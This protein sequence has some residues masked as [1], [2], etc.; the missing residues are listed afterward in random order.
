MFITS[1]RCSTQPLCHVRVRL[2][3][4]GA[5]IL[6]PL[7]G[8]EINVLETVFDGLSPQSRQQRFLVPMPRLPGSA[9]KALANVDGHDHVAWVAM[10]DGQPV[11]IC[12]YVRTGPDTAEVAFEVVDAEQGRGIGLALVDAVTTV[13][14]A[15]GITSL[16][17]TVEPDNRASVAMLS[18]LGIRLSMDDGLLEGSGQFRLLTPPSRVDRRAV[19]ALS[20]QE[21]A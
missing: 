15:N 2:A 3:D 5:V 7:H 18:R 4:G 11:G 8:G 21:P 9:R 17:A 10:L 14:R 13:A 1:T 6:R 20:G 19:L 16:E 12:R